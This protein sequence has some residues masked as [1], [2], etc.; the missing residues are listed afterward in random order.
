MRETTE[1]W[2]STDWQNYRGQIAKLG[3][4]YLVGV[5]VLAGAAAILNWPE[6]V[7]VA[8]SVPAILLAGAYVRV[9]WEVG[10]F[11][12]AMSAVVAGLLVLGAVTLFAFLGLVV[13]V[14][15]WLTTGRGF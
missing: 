6:A 4:L 14:N 8:W 12:T 7:T 15:I 3:G 13:A 2:S 9:G 11:R 10:I 1:G 5:A